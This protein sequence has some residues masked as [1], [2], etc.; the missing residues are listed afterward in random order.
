ML[1]VSLTDGYLSFL[2]IYSTIDN[3]RQS[4]ARPFCSYLV[5]SYFLLTHYS[6]KPVPAR[7]WLLDFP[8]SAVRDY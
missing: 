6:P 2:S 3:R 8:F 1:L 5:P 4:Q 7:T